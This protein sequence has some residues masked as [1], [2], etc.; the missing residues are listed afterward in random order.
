LVGFG[1][2]KWSDARLQVNQL[3]LLG[4]EPS[5]EELKVNPTL[6]RAW[7]DAVCLDLIKAGDKSTQEQLNDPEFAAAWRGVNNTI[8]AASHR[9][10]QLQDQGERLGWQPCS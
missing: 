6:R 8:A 7:N 10:K 5:Q 4:E 9:V 3:R 2:K 1:S